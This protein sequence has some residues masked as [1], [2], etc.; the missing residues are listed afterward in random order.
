M[1]DALLENLHRVQLNP[2]EEASAYKQ[3]LED[4]GCTQEELA[5]RIARSRSQLT[6]TL[7]LPNYQSLFKL[8]TGQLTNGH[9][10]TLL[11]LKKSR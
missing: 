7:R 5:S 11:G 1:R 9:A 2:I 3:L 8:S 6:N 10:K 4:F